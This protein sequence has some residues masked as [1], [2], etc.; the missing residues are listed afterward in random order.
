MFIMVLALCF[1]ALTLGLIS[2]EP[3]NPAVAKEL[4]FR[5]PEVPP[6]DNAYIGIFG[7]SGLQDGD[8]VTAGKKYYENGCPKDQEPSQ[9][10]DYSY[11]SPCLGQARGNCLDQLVADA[12][13]IKEAVQKNKEYIDRYHIVQKMPLYVNSSSGLFDPAPS[14]NHLVEISKLIGDKALLDIKQGDLAGGLDAIEKDLNFYKKTGHGEYISLVDLMVT[15]ALVKRHI[16]GLSKIIED[17]R[18]NLS[19]ER[20][21][22]R[23]TLELEFDAGRMMTIALKAEERSLLKMYDSI[24]SAA[25]P[26]GEGLSL[27]NRLEQKFTFK[28]NMTLNRAAA[29]REKIIKLHQAAPLLNFP[30]YHDQ[31]MSEATDQESSF[32][33][34]LEFKNLYQKYGLFFFK[35]YYGEVLLGLGSPSY[36]PY[37]ATVRDAIVYS[38]LVRAQ[39]ELRLMPNRPENISEALAGLGPETWNPYTG[40]PFQWDRD[41]NVLWAKTARTSK[42]GDDGLAERKIQVAVPPSRP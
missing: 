15:V 4:A 35:N 32:E 11:R 5:Y 23:K 6:S 21:R 25:I 31:H 28:K 19:G 27:K 30:D 33:S 13:V 18:I 29:Q 36:A 3:L 8:V 40:K 42:A 20:E 26:F 22:L 1:P 7:L 37:G 41:N 16:I 34:G 24:Y 12:A 9:N 17:S 10:F 14:Y 38:R 2:D 39:L